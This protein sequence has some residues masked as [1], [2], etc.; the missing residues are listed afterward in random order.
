VTVSISLPDEI[1]KKA[2]EFA[3]QSHV[4]LEQVLT[5]VVVGQV[6]AWESLQTRAARGSH[7]QLRAI[8]AR[9]PDVDPDEQ[10]RP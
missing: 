7:D 1:V 2:Q 9:V 8:M 5:S 4:S 6:A 3:S 10:D